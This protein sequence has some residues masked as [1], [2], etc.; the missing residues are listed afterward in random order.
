[1]SYNLKLNPIESKVYVVLSS[2]MVEWIP[3]FPWETS[4]SRRTDEA[5]KIEDSQQ[6]V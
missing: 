5:V 4:F 6:S 2:R 1:M 3:L